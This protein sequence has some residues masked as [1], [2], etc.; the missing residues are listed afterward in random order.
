MG[1]EYTLKLMASQSKYVHFIGIGGSGAS[2]IAAIA[3][4]QG[5]KVSGC[6]RSPYNE[7]TKMFTPDQ[8]LEGHSYDHM[9]RVDIL[10][11]TPALTS[12][13]PNNPELVAAKD[14]GLEVLTW[15]EFMGKYL[16]RGQKVIAICGT[17][18]KSTT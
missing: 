15:Q 12:L 3:Q 1:L 2:A 9:E 7:L 4:A 8:L 14:K 17:H 5:Y 6:E 18:G 11:I 10:A 16:E 13:D